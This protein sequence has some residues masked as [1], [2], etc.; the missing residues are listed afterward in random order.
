MTHLQT[1]AWLGPLLIAAWYSAIP[2]IFAAVGGVVSERSGVPNIAL[3]GFLL[4]GAFTA[5]W[6]GQRDPVLG[7]AFALLIGTLLGLLYALLTQNLRVDPIISGLS[8]NLLAAGATQYLAMTLY[9]SGIEVGGLLRWPFLLLSILVPL[10][11]WYGLR[12]T[13][14]GLRIRSVGED[15]MA[16]SL[17]GISTRKVRYIAL[18]ISGALGSLGG[19]FLSLVDAH[20]F[21]SNMSAG[22]GYIALAL[23]VFGEWNPIRVVLGALMF[24]FLYAIQTQVQ[25]SGWHWNLLGINWTD[26][27]LL[28]AVPYVMTIAV[29]AVTAARVKPP[30]ALSQQAAGD[31]Q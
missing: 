10:A 29:L 26:S 14:L 16:A 25:I 7:L 13:R 4:F 19:V 28:D 30:A 6:A 27:Q 21:S 8:I 3:E 18:A 2:I 9:P 11:A 17:A 24:G 12:N 20:T 5:V 15:P 23:V 22:K 1:L 31:G